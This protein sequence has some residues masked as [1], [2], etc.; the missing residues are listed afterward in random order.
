MYLYFG[1]R[2]CYHILSATFKSKFRGLNDLSWH[3]CDIYRK[4]IPVII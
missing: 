1:N 4:K 3:S 2:V